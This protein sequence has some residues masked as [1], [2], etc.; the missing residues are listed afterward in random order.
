VARCNE[1]TQKIR[2]ENAMGPKLLF[3]LGIVATHGAL[4]AAWMRTETLDMRT[5]TSTCVK[6]PAP[7]P[8]FQ[9]RSELLAMQVTPVA[10]GTPMQP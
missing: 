6:A 7:L 5:P 3:V 2:S 9:A 10:A 8:Y 1:Q 4:G